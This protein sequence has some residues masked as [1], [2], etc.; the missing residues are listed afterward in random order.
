MKNIIETPF[1]KTVLNIFGDG[2]PIL[3]VH[4]GPGFSHNYLVDGILPLAEKR[5]LIF[6][7][8]PT[9]ENTPLPKKEFSPQT[10]FAHFRWLA[11]ELSQTDP[12]GIIAHSWG[13][14]VVI[15]GLTEPTLQTKPPPNLSRVLLLNTMP[16]TAKDLIRSRKNLMG[17]L[18][19]LSKIKLIL[20]ICTNASR[21]KIMNELLPYYVYDQSCIPKDEFKFSK[22]T[23]LKILQHL[24]SYDFEKEL[25]TLPEVDLLLSKQDFITSSHLQPLIE[26]AEN[27]FT[28]KKS[29]HFPMWE[30]PKDFHVVI[31]SVFT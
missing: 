31:Q 15:A 22:K 25:G 9:F 24:K 23:Y 13:G 30:N 8:Q 12:L 16:L 10:I 26:K 19:W 20:S 27:Q 11:N 7:D 3:V 5:S 1:G 2:P 28:I 6:Y 29:V 14:L 4:G 21:Q 17:R 18:S